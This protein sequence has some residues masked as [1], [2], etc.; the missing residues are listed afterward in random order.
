MKLSIL[1]LALIAVTVNVVYAAPRGATSDIQG[2]QTLLKKVL[3]QSAQEDE[4]GI[5]D[6]DAE[7]QSPQ[8]E[9]GDIQDFLASVQ[10]GDEGVEIQDL[11]DLLASMQDDEDAE[12]QEFF[13]REQIPA[14]MQRWWKKAWRKIK[15]VGRKVIHYGTR[16]GPYLSLLGK[17]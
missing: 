12:L 11:Q 2:L 7:L 17:K 3:E 1:L 9:E 13:A 6:K 8:E 14:H 15:K 4:R 5:Q 16:Y 10:Q